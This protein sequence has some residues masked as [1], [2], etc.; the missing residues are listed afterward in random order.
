MRV[1]VCIC[2]CIHV[3][4]EQRDRAIA[5]TQDQGKL[6]NQLTTE[7]DS[8]STERDEMAA[9]NRQYREQLAAVR[10]EVSRFLCKG[11]YLQTPS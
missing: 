4:L 1:R 7:R 3:F 8:I 11:W 5:V 10:A 2:G 6:V 9:Q